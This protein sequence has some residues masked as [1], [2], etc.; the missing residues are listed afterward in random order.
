MKYITYI[1][2]GRGCRGAR[3]HIS[4]YNPCINLS[5]SL[6]NVSHIYIFDGA[7]GAQDDVSSS[8]GVS[9]DV[10]KG[11]CAICAEMV[12]LN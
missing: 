4:M 9:G 12:G 7:A 8:P 10:E 6:S 3:S 5:I 11:L 2:I 1:H